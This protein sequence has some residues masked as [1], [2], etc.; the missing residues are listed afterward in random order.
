MISALVLPTRVGLLH[1][2]GPKRPSILRARAPRKTVWPGPAAVSFP[3]LVTVRLWPPI[4][5]M[6]DGRNESICVMSQI[7]RLQSVKLSGGG[8]GGSVVALEKHHSTRST[9]DSSSPPPA[10][11]KRTDASDT[12]SMWEKESWPM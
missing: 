9:G 11:P 1:T 6:V 2:H 5:M 7:G 12:S 3:K 8:S 4:L 10:D